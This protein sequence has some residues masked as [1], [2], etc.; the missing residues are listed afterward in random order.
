M[1]VNTYEMW[2]ISVTGVSF[3]LMAGFMVL[4]MWSVA[5]R[6]K[7]NRG[8]NAA[9]VKLVILSNLL[10]N[11]G[12]VEDPKAAYLLEAVQGVLK[13]E[14]DFNNLNKVQRGWEVLSRLSGAPS[15]RQ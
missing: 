1:G 4:L 9:Q 8:K 14:V 15:E 6:I 12:R 7:E 3:I 13:G 5:I 11:V 10:A 2:C